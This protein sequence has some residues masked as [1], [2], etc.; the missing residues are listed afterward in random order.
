MGAAGDRSREK[1][2]ATYFCVQHTLLTPYAPP[3]PTGA[4]LLAWSA[5]D[6]DFWRSGRD[7]KATVVGSQLF[8]NAAAEPIDE[9]DRGA[10]ITYLGQLHGTELPWNAPRERP[11]GSASITM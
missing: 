7:E 8:W 11:S 4:H 10:A 1:W 5:E 2:G 6:A 9:P 3:P